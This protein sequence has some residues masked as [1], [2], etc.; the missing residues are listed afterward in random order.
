VWKVVDEDVVRFSFYTELLGAM[1][2]TD[3]HHLG[4]PRFVSVL[5]DQVT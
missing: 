5:V 3:G 2:G 1:T 4:D